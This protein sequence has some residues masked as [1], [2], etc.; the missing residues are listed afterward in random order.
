VAAYSNSWRGKVRHIAPQIR[1]IF[2]LDTRR[3]SPPCSGLPPFVPTTSFLTPQTSITGHT[4]PQGTRL[5]PRGGPFRPCPSRCTNGTRQSRRGSCTPHPVYARTGALPYS[6]FAEHGKV[7]DPPPPLPPYCML[8]PPPPFAPCPRL[9]TNGVSAGVTQGQGRC[10][11]LPRE[12]PSLRP[13]PRSCAN[14]VRADAGGWPSPHL[15]PAP[16]Q[17]RRRLQGRGKVCAPSA[18]DCSATGGDDDRDHA[19]D[20]AATTTATQRQQPPCDGT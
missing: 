19:D 9:C 8:T 1:T 14:R 6:P 10:P 2:S 11:F 12:P 17:P 18:L 13:A 5:L 3:L 7:H 16:A 20:N 4:E 15:C